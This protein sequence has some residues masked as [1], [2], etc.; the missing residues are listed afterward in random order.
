MR[1]RSFPR[2]IG[3]GGIANGDESNDDESSAAMPLLGGGQACQRARFRH[4]RS[5]HVMLAWAGLSIHRSASNE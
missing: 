5:E 3:G 2:G 1:R 4:R